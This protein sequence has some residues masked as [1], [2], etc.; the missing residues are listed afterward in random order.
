M[1]GNVAGANWLFSLPGHPT[2]LNLGAAYPNQQFNAVIWGEQRRQWPLSGK[3]DVIY[4]NHTICVTGLIQMYKTWPQIQD[5]Q[6]S[7]LQVIN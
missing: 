7:D 5:V 2:W 6:M 4:L 3:P 1:C